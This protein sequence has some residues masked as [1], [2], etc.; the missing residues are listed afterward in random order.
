MNSRIEGGLKELELKIKGPRSEEFIACYHEE[1]ED[2]QCREI[3]R[4]LEA[5]GKE[6]GVVQS[7]V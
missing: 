7:C 4:T 1:T 5:E 6:R 2:C 3:A